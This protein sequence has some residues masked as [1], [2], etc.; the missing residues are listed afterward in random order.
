MKKPL[1]TIN[2]LFFV[3]TSI[4]LFSCNNQ[5]SKNVDVNDTTEI[6]QTALTDRSF[7]KDHIVAKTDTLFFLKSKNFNKQ[8]PVESKYFKILYIP[9]TEDA[10]TVLGPKGKQDTRIRIGIP[11]FNIGKDTASIVLFNFGYNVEY[12][13]KLKKE[14]KIWK[15]VNSSRRIY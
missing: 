2:I 11:E 13:L 6:I 14:N 10:R 12:L 7:L 9:D 4:V 15:I 5:E 3:L 1:K 8:W